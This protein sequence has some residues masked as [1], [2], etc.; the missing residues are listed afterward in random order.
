MTI[1]KQPVELTVGV[2]QQEPKDCVRACVATLFDLPLADVPRF[3]AE[4]WADELAEWL[5]PMGFSLINMRFDGTQEKGIP[6]GY[7][8]GAVA[9][10]SL[11]P[12]YKH[13]VV[14]LNGEVVWC[15][16]YGHEFVHKP[17][18][19][20]TVIYP[21]KPRVPE[22]E[23]SNQGDDAGESRAGVFYGTR[24][25]SGNRTKEVKMNFLDKIAL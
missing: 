6:T 23:Y 10:D 11:P 19:E 21:V 9:S 1:T 22:R 14:C 3:S 2:L 18:D 25:D 15:P 17:V 5:R 20:Y 8:L 4:A 7:T 24:P 16:T 13:C 12:P